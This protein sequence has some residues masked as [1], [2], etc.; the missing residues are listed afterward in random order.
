MQ[1]RSLRGESTNTCRVIKCVEE[2]EPGEHPYTCDMCSRL[3]RWC[4]YQHGYWLWKEYDSSKTLTLYQREGHFV[5]KARV[6]SA[7]SGFNYM[8]FGRSRADAEQVLEGMDKAEQLEADDIESLGE[9]GIE[10]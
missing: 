10:L 4:T 9:G 1:N 2:W 8:L 6:M 7:P 3:R 5:D